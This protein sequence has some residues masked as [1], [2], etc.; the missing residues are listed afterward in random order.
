MQKIKLE[1]SRI[2]LHHSSSMKIT[3]IPFVLLFLLCGG[4]VSYNNY[5][6][7]N[8]NYMQ[9]REKETRNFDIEDEKV[10]IT[11]SAQILQDLGFVI[12]ETEKK[13]GLISASKLRDAS[14]AGAA[15]GQV[16]LAILIGVWAPRDVSQK[17]YATMTSTKSKISGFDVRIDFTRVIWDD[18]GNARVEPI[19]DFKIYQDFF[20]KLEKSVFLTNNNL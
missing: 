7:L 12:N 19:E 9:R 15:I 17:I 2:E 13:L 11:A 14:S 6:R 3:K 20:E 18:R 16:A 8:D 10:I 4:C 5:Y 1:I